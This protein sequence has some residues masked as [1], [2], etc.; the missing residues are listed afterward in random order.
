MVAPTPTITTV[1]VAAMTLFFCEPTYSLVSAFV[2]P[3]I[4]PHTSHG[5]QPRCCTD[6]ALRLPAVAVSVDELEKDLTPAERSVTSV[7]RNC[8]P[9]VAFITS[10]LPEP[11]SNNNNN[12][13]NRRR[14][15]RAPSPPNDD[16]STGNNNS[17]APGESL[18]S[19][20]GFV[21]AQDGYL[22][23]NYHVIERAYTVRTSAERI[24]SMIDQLAG[25]ITEKFPLPGTTDVVNGTKTFL[26]RS[27]LSVLGAT[28][29]TTTLGELLPVVYV[30]IN[31]SKKYLKCRIV[32][33]KPD[34][35]LAVL[36]ILPEDDK[37]TNETSTEKVEYDTIPFGSSSSMLVGQTV[38]AVG[39]PFSLEN[40]VTTG[41]VSS[42]NREFR[43]GTARTPANTPI[44]NVIQTDA[45]INP[46][47]SGGPLLNLR[48][49]VVGIN[50]AIVTTSG[51]SAGIG[52]AVPSDQ[53]QPVVDEIV[54]KDRLENTVLGSRQGWLGLSIVDQPL[55]ATNET[56]TASVLSTWVSKVEPNSPA[57]EAGIRP[58]R[59]VTNTACV[60]YGDAIVAIGGNEVTTLVEIQKQLQDRVVGEQLAITLQDST[61]ER[62]VVYATLSS[63]PKPKDGATAIR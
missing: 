18:G 13:N 41:V 63:K 50:T 57:S 61:G 25:N 19:G 45:A 33:V 11:A 38:V 46:G 14:R 31:S 48:G 32:G 53:V 15:R 49:E 30:K 34:I 40:T 43:A 1:I 35:D 27:L 28:P 24:E 37:T 52:F 29:G 17:P 36:K 47:N 8:G 23:T 42:V 22:A 20:S 59:I 2:V 26:S 3:Q 39:N 9:A 12:N 4:H 16:D 55:P 54:R 58:L 60:V 44:R 10:V 21:V 62:R 56:K 6:S 7:V 5:Q 51:G